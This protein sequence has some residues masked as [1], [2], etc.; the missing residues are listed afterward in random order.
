MHST[1]NRY[2]RVEKSNYEIVNTL[3]AELN[4]K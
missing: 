1:L 3:Q 2:A 4:G